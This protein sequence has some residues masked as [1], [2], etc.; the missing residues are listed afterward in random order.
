MSRTVVRARFA[1]LTAALMLGACSG[2]MDGTG[3]PAGPEALKGKAAAGATAVQQRGCAGCHSSSAG[4][5]AGAAGGKAGAANLTPDAETGLGEWKD[6]DIISAIRDGI[7]DEQHTLCSSMPRSKDLSDEEA[8]NIVAYL[9]SLKPVSNEVPEAE[10]MVSKN[11]SAHH[12]K[13]VVEAQHCAACHGDDLAGDD[14]SGG[15]EVFAANLTPDLAT[16]LGGW[17]KQALAAA[18]TKGTDDEGGMLCSQ[19]PRFANLTENEVT[20]VAEYLATVAPVK[21]QTPKSTCGS[22]E[23]DPVKTGKEYATNR[24]CTGCHT[25]S[26]GGRPSCGPGEPSN[27]TGT[28]L[29]KW[30][31]QQ[32]ITAMRTG[33]DEEGKMLGSKMPRY[34]TMGDD[35]AKDIVA[36]LRSVPNVVRPGCTIDGAPVDAGVIPVDGGVT[37]VDAGAPVVDAGMPPFDAGTVDA[38]TPPVDAGV[39]CGSPVVISQLY[40]GGGNIGAVYNADFV[41]LHNRTAAEVNLTGWSIQYASASG[42]SWKSQLSVLP[43]Q[44]RIGAGAYLLVAI[45]PLGSNGVALPVTAVTPSRVIDMSATSGKLA[46]TRAA[47]ALS[48]ACPVDA[49]IVDFVGYGT[50]SCPEGSSAAPPLSSSLSASRLQLSGPEMACV[51]SEVNAADFAKVTPGPHGSKVN[52]CRCELQ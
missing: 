21:R 14:G 29:G 44:T 15:G 40:G 37:W 30:S 26:L 31:D 33:V 50:A 28:N 39:G 51:D 1:V 36:F 41:E 20:G 18:I 22:D 19:M 10:C 45:G 52:V 48:G 16:G 11:D 13:K 9:R 4:A 17:S 2:T 43:A 34:G 24:K 8:A 25:A 38:G 7:D 27:L 47:V 6:E 46:L 42:T 49:S 12:G 23:A 5:F 3:T 32:I 35:E